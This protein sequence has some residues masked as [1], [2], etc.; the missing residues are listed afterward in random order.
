MLWRSVLF[1]ALFFGAILTGTIAA[2]HHFAVGQGILAWVLDALGSIA[3]TILAMWLFL[4]LARGIRHV[5]FR[6]DRPGGGTPL[7]P[8]HAARPTCTDFGAT[9]GRYFTRAA[10]IGT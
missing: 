3:A 2:V 4:P 7:L 9:R 5:V 1:S 6:T 10:G 8:R